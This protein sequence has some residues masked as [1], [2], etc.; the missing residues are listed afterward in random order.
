MIVFLLIHHNYP[1]F[2]CAAERMY[3]TVVNTSSNLAACYS[4]IDGSQIISNDALL[5]TSASS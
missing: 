3:I 2:N 1:F 4:P 5:S